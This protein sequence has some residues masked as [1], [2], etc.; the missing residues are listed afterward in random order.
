MNRFIL[1]QLFVL[2]ATFSLQ[3][4][5]KIGDNPS[6]INSNSMLEIESTDRGLLVPRVGLKALNSSSPMDAH[7]QG[8]TVYN[9]ENEGAFPYQ[10]TPGY[11][12]NDGSQWLRLENSSATINRY[13][14]VK[15]G[16]QSTDHG[17]WYILDGRQISSLSTHA[18]AAAVSLGFSTNLPD[19][20]NKFLQHGIAPGTI[21]GAPN[22]MIK[23]QRIN[24]PVVNFTGL[25]LS[26]GSHTHLIHPPNTY[27]NS[28]GSHAHIIDP[29]SVITSS[30]GNH[31]HTGKASV[32]DVNNSSSQGF[33]SGNVHN[34][35]RSSDRAGSQNVN[36]SA[37][38]SAGAHSH[39]INIGAFNSLTAGAHTHLVDMPSFSS[40]SSGSH[41]HPVQ[42]SSGGSGADMDITPEY[43]SINNFIYLGQ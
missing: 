9:T 24:L 33:P 3:A 22:H 17:G 28:S 31:T 2:V 8:M 32:N 18:Q 4:Q 20:R 27:T 34:S 13:G 19:S 29:P 37:I 36:Q 14:D 35:F 10:V 11:Y 39:F 26:E 6:S 1:F 30:N 25:A 40:A 23:I 16:F 21:G 15:Q 41:T 42:V 5:V 7:V 43:L 12:I 38:S